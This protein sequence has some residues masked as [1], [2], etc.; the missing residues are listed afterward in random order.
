VAGSRKETVNQESIVPHVPAIL[1][2]HE[3]RAELIRIT[4]PS[5][6]LSR[7]VLYLDTTR[8]QLVFRAYDDRAGTWKP[9]KE[10]A[11]YDHM[12]SLGIPAPQVFRVDSTRR[13]AP[14]VYSLS[15]RIEGEPFSA[16]FD[17]LSVSENCDIYASLGDF[18]GRLHSTT[19]NRFGEIHAS[20]AGLAI[21]PI[22]E[23]E[24]EEPDVRSGPFASWREMHGETVSARL[25]LMR[26]TEFEDLIPATERFF[27]ERHDLLDFE[28]V[29]R[30][31]HMD[32]HRGNVL[33]RD[34]EVAA[35]LDVEEA[36]AG[37][38]E[39]D[40]MR[41]EL[42]NFRDQPPELG[43]SFL[44]AYERHVALDEGYS[45]RKDF[46]DASRTL[47]WITCLIQLGDAYSRGVASQSHEAARDH[48]LSLVR[49]DGVAR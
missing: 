49:A 29:S 22:H 6:G 47:V 33:I 2:E 7:S 1:A 15:E 26:D 12:R 23:L 8:G 32:L 17:S 40:L 11:I 39:Y 45:S 14:F 28:I 34:G 38:N 21:G 5:S 10:R 18:L 24:S 25:R 20:S 46:Y 13:V 4:R 19:F 31:L 37:H 9:E 43:Q 44:R 36:V 48:L 35:I 30:L 27:S 42:A 3:P 41:T 16:V